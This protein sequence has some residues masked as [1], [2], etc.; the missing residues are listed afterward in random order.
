MFHNFISNQFSKRKSR[1]DSSSSIH[2]LPESIEDEIKARNFSNIVLR[3]ESSKDEIVIE[4]FQ[5]EKWH[6]ILKSWGS[7]EGIHL[8]KL[9][10]RPPLT[11]DSGSNRIR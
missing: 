6:P 8:I 1:R 9:F 10:D 3:D 5:N 2:Q 7:I 11:D 4:V